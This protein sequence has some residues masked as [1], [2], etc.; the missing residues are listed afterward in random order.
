MNELTLRYDRQSA[1][2]PLPSGDEWATREGVQ[3]DICLT[4]MR[5]ARAMGVEV[6][7]LSPIGEGPRASISPRHWLGRGSRRG[8]ACE[9]V[10]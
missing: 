7:S 9:G 6:V 10:R 5:A 4:A 3:I 8:S 1:D 2:E